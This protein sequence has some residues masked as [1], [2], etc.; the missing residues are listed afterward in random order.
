MNQKV[1]SLTFEKKIFCLKKKTFFII[2]LNITL[3]RSVTGLISESLRCLIAYIDFSFSTYIN[4][5]RGRKVYAKNVRLLCMYVRIYIYIL[6][7]MQS[8]NYS[9]IEET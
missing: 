5:V 4:Y 3:Y 1:K 7:K 6:T 2:R 8:F 9:Y